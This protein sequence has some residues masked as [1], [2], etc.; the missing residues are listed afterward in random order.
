[1]RTGGSVLRPALDSMRG[2]R[3]GK[4]SMVPVNQGKSKLACSRDFAVEGVAYSSKGHTE[5]FFHSRVI[6]AWL[7]VTG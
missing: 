1:M 5:V 7:V 2:Q 6:G 3:H 4:H